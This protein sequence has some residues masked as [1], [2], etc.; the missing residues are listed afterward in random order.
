MN[1][2]PHRS[3][4]FPETRWGLILRIAGTDPDDR[5]RAL[6]EICELYRPPIYSFIRNLGHS[7]HDADDLTQEFF[8]NFLK[9]DCFSR[10]VA[11][12][13]KLRAFLLTAVKRFLTDEHRRGMRQ[14]RG[15][16]A[17]VVSIEAADEKGGLPLGLQSDER[18]PEVLFD[19][20]WAEALLAR[21][22]ARLEDHYRKRREDEI[23]DLLCPYL[24]TDRVSSEGSVTPGMPGLTEGAFRV[25]LHRFRARYRLLMQEEVAATIEPGGDITE[26]IRYLRSLFG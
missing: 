24:R 5:S 20:Q 23:F 8:A 18:S 6:E 21:V 22:L 9:K 17:V 19:R 14:K 15:G 11:E 7:P 3:D 25:R 12:R 13:G 2:V 16:G 26:E 1:E 4:R 10:P